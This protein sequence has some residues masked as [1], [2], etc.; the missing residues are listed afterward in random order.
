MHRNSLRDGQLLTVEEVGRGGTFRW[1]AGYNA[2][3]DGGTVFSLV[4]NGIGRW[5]RAVREPMDARWFGA[6]PDASPIE[7]TTAFQAAGKAIA[8]R[9]G[10]LVVP[11]GKYWI[12]MQR[13]AQARG[14]GFAY[15]TESVIQIDGCTKQV[16]LVGHGAVL[17]CAPRLRYG[18]FDP[19][20][21][22][23]TEHAT[24]DAD[25]RAAPYSYMIDVRN[26][27][28][29]VHVEGFEL[30]GSLEDHVLGGL[31]GDRG[32]QIQASGIYSFANTGGVTIVN[33]WTHHHALD[34]VTVAHP[35]LGVDAPSYPV[36]LMDVRSEYNGRQGLS[37]IGGTTLRAAR[38][39]FN[40]TGRAGFS[41]SPAAGVDIE[42]EDSICRGGLFVD[43]EFVGN[44]GAGLLADT[45][46][47][48]DATFER[49]VF[50]GT[51][52]YA[53]WPRKPRLAFQNCEIVGTLVNVFQDMDPDL[54]T[55]F[56]GCRFSTD[57]KR[58]P[59]GRIYNGM[60]ADLGGGA[61]N[62]LF[63]GCEFDASI[64][65]GVLPWSPVGTLYHDCKFRQTGSLMSY[66]R[67]AFT[68]IN[69][70]SSA[71]PVDLQGATFR[72]VVTLNGRKISN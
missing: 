62:V 45:G 65:S 11:P 70:I 41:S 46:S 36:V 50:V 13:L 23:A 35:N 51:S 61:M 9:G 31:W 69:V 52:Y 30:D 28:G 7:N 44:V 2:V 55:K 6:G 38:C 47:V 64:P 59:D 40:H 19:V 27:S 53:L 18:Q 60:L 68:G 29:P 48:S 20:T 1:V 56:Y 71:G 16:R 37:W 72:G 34:G 21:G 17:K 58:S 49:C 15:L 57:Q 4:D 25:H 26:C 12:G 39:R 5:V 24:T 43:C 32:R 3:P 10:T 42:A 14:K 54:A 63:S 67:G 22:D 66:P 33:I 8:A